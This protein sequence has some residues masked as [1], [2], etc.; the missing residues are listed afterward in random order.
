[1]GNAMILG[2][3]EMLAEVYALGDATGIDPD[4]FQQFVEMFFPT[5]SYQVYGRKIGKGSFDAAGGFRLEGGLKGESGP[6]RGRPQAARTKEVGQQMSD[7]D[8]K[9]LGDLGD[10]LYARPPPGTPPALALAPRS[11]A[12]A[13]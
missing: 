4:V 3:M 8:G 2:M 13:R 9:C 5:P 12:R 11:R 10:R 7:G 1:M 6:V